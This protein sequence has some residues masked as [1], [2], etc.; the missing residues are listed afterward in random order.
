M[1]LLYLC[2]PVSVFYLFL[3]V[4]FSVCLLFLSLYPFSDCF[5]FSVSIF[6]LSVSCFFI[7]IFCQSLVSLSI[8][9]L[10]VSSFYISVFCLSQGRSL[11]TASFYVPAFVPTGSISSSSTLQRFQDES[12]KSSTSWAISQQKRPCSQPHFKY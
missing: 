3:C 2:L 7:S 9:R 1:L 10:P 5:C 6:Y 4:L 12:H 11:D 8:F